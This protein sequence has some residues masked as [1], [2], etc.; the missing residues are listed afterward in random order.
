MDYFSIVGSCNGVLCLCDN[1]CS[2]NVCI[3]LWNP[4]IHV[5]KTL[6]LPHHWVRT[7]EYKYKIVYGIGFDSRNNDYKVVMIVF[8][9]E[10]RQGLPV[11][12]APKVEA[13]ELYEL[14]ANT[15]RNNK[16]VPECT[17][18]YDD[19]TPAFLNGAVHWI[20][21]YPIVS[22]NRRG[23]RDHMAIV[24]FDLGDVSMPKSEVVG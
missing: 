12:S 19:V 13:V 15:W 7:G 24:L 18:I 8:V 9:R 11:N 1:H 5:S 22:I 20:G 4:S 16:A 3:N 6:P 2:D 10:E 14:S 23:I 17:T 21:C